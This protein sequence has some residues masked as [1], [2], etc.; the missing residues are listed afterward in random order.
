MKELSWAVALVSF[1]YYVRV[2]VRACPS[3][4]NKKIDDIATAPATRRLPADQ[5]LL[6]S[7]SLMLLLLLRLFLGSSS[8]LLLFL[9][10]FGE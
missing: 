4:R 7:G 5:W 3:S 2:S 6:I 9:I 10:L 8:L 1:T